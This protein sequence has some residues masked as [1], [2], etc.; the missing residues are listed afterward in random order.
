MPFVAA[1]FTK[2]VGFTLRMAVHGR[3]R[4]D[5]LPPGRIYCCWHGRSF[6]PG[7]QMRGKGLWAIFSLS[8]DGEMQSRI[9]KRLGYRVIRGSSG[10]GGARAAI[11]AIRVLRHGDCMAIT[12]DGPRGP[13][14]VAQMGV[15][16]MAKKSGAPMV[17][18]GSAASPA[19]R[20]SSWDR[21]L[22]PWPFARAAVAFGEPVLVPEDASDEQLEAARSALE[23]ALN[24]A[25]REAARSLGL[26]E[27][28]RPA[29]AAGVHR[30]EGPAATKGD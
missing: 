17:P 28:P 21:F 16:L 3:E 1:A 2:L 20:V 13:S 27:E 4:L 19:W 23:H 11:E 24:Q 25:D 8:N 15:V 30:T 14:H 5:G 10:R 26:K 9:Y 18:I 29:G 6:L 7:F 12:P 22:V